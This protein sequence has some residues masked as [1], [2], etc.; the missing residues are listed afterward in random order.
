VEP[1]ELAPGIPDEV[2]ALIVKCMKF[3]PKERYDLGG[4]KAAL[5]R[6]R[7]MRNLPNQG[8]TK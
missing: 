4:L 5:R 7:N 2:N 8:G 6:L 3:S 1:K